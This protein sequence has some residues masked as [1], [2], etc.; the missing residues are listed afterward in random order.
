MLL[1]DRPPTCTLLFHFPDAVRSLIERHFDPIERAFLL[2][3]VAAKQPEP[4]AGIKLKAAMHYFFGIDYTSDEPLTEAALTTAN[5]DRR[6][7]K[8]FMTAHSPNTGRFDCFSSFD[9]NWQAGEDFFASLIQ[10]E[11]ALNTPYHKLNQVFAR[12]PGSVQLVRCPAGQ[13][14][15]LTADRQQVLARRIERTWAM[16]TVDENEGALNEAALAPSVQFVFEREWP[17]KRA[18]LERRLAVNAEANDGA[19]AGEAN[20]GD[21]D[22]AGRDDD[23]AGQQAGRA[24]IMQ[25][26]QQQLQQ[27]QLSQKPAQQQPAQLQPAQ[28]QQQQPGQELEPAHQQQEPE[29]ERA[30]QQHVVLLQ[31]NEERPKRRTH[32]QRELSGLLGMWLPWSREPAAERNGKRLKTES[33]KSSS[34]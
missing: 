24:P 29:Q 33:A 25:Q 2:R 5:W 28:Q 6:A 21:D 12:P 13:A 32:V 1:G 7:G 27:Q 31:V 10:A 19:R 34:T 11:R 20:D 4:C 30:Q 26:Q 22:D 17:A 15:P 3:W 16:A 8:V 18:E 9:S 23:D 14:I